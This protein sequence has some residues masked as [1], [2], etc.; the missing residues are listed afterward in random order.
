MGCDNSTDPKP[1]TNSPKL[2]LSADKTTGNS[3]L[4]ITFNSN[5]VG[6]INGLT[7]QVPDYF[8][9]KSGHTLIPYAIPDTSKPVTREWSK[10]EILNSGQHKFVLMFQGEKENQ[11]YKLYSDTLVISVN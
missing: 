5:L 9:F 10:T 2:Y 8:L 1:Q 11:Y 4:T 3:P 6:D 7:A